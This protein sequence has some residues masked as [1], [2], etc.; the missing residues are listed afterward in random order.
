LGSLNDILTSED[1]FNRYN[2]TMVDG[3]GVGVGVGVGD[4]IGLNDALGVGVGVGVGE[5]LGDGIRNVFVIE[6]NF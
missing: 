3:V 2:G 1:N 6:P 4:G 5:G